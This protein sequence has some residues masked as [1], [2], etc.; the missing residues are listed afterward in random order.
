MVNVVYSKAK[1]LRIEHCWFQ[2]GA[3]GE[4]IRLKKSDILFLHG[5]PELPVG[6]KYKLM[7]HQRTLIKDLSPSPDD[8]WATFGSHLRNNIK[9][10]ERDGTIVRIFPSDDAAI[11]DKLLHTV[12]EIY[13]KM[14]CDKGM[15]GRF[16]LPLA[17]EYA[18]NGILT[19]AIAYVSGEPVGFDA[20]IYDGEAA[21]SWL[22][23]YDFRNKHRN[24]RD[25]GDA[26]KNVQW[27]LLIWCK[28]HGVTRF[29]FGGAGSLESPD[30]ITQFKMQFV[31][32]AQLTEYYNLL[33]PKSPL[34][35]FLLFC[36]GVYTKIR[37]LRHVSDQ[38]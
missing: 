35:S 19:I 33:I 26:H 22:S 24:S 31:P 25:I 14:F 3:I 20:V 36:Y 32:E 1:L 28:E 23:A 5:H 16:N 27:R 34:G 12:A 7:L 18:R 2:N 38:A 17:R 37:R 4:I 30:G 21:R 10:S 6:I 9:K 15:R 8:L 29:D 11:D 13:E